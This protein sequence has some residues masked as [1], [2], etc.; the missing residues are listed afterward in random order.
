MGVMKKR[1]CALLVGPVALGRRDVCA[2][3]QK[4]L[5]SL[6]FEECQSCR[7]GFPKV[8][9]I[10]KNTGQSVTQLVDQILDD[11]NDESPTCS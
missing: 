8:K 3:K 9:G 11:M 7:Y 10:N 4:C 5:G 6:S 1:L 2:Q